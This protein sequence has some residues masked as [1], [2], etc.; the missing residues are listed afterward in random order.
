MDFIVS[1]A[2]MQNGIITVQVYFLLVIGLD[3]FEIG[4]DRGEVAF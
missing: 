4:L 2:L 3:I 1:W